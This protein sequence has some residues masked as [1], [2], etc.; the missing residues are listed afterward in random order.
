MSFHLKGGI[1]QFIYSIFIERFI[2]H[3]HS[4]SLSSVIQPCPTL[5]NPIDC[6]MP[7][8]PVRHQLL[9][10]V[11]THVHQV[12]NAIQPSHPLLSLLLP[13]VFPSI[14][15][16]LSELL[17]FNTQSCPTLCDTINCSTPGF[18]VLLCLPESTLSHVH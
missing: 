16:F 4:F 18:P 9:E 5:C 6:S 10:L 7:G 1:Y 11:Q 17:L 2:F 12:G 8:F 3:F 14:R 13:S 15:V